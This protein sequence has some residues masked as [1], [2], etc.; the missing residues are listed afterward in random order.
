[1]IGTSLLHPHRTIRITISSAFNASNAV[2]HGS[3]P[4]SDPYVISDWLFNGSAYP[5]STAMVRIENTDQHVIVQNCQVIHF[6]SIHQF[7]AFYVGKYPGENTT[8]TIAP[9]LIDLT[10]NVRVLTK[11]IA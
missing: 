7:D 4:A 5:S 8:P 9:P 10:R 3:V 6:D 1:M 11:E 2:R